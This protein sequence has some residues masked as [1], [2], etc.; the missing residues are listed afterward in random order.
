[1]S[2]HEKNLRITIDLQLPCDVNLL[3]AYRLKEMGVYLIVLMFSKAY[4]LI[5]EKTRA[6]SHELSRKQSW[7]DILLCPS[8]SR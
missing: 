4:L 1:M 2:F 3:Q 5:F 7:I 6:V 8:V